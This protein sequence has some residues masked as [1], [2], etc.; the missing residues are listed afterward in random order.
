MNGLSIA[1]TKC[2][3]RYAVVAIA[4]AA[5]AFLGFKF[6]NNV[7]FTAVGGLLGFLLGWRF[8]QFRYGNPEYARHYPSARLSLILSG[9]A[10][11]IELLVLCCLLLPE[12]LKGDDIRRPA[13]FIM[14]P[15][16]MFL[17]IFA[18]PLAR[19]SAHHAFKQISEGTKPGSD[20]A[21]ARAG[22]NL[23]RM[24]TG[25]TLL[26]VLWIGTSLTS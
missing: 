23:S 18:G 11:L 16:T 25:L 14:F 20:T 21:M 8:A 2:V 26:C 1:R 6:A 24:F 7:D 5:G 4:V 12:W 17:W 10:W 9:G 19:S 3:R 13:F 22:L 15:L